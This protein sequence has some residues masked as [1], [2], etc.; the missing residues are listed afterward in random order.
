M[1]QL[2]PIFFFTI[3]F[4]SCVSTKTFREV[5]NRYANLKMEYKSILEKNKLLN[6]S[7]DSIIQFLN[8]KSKLLEIIGDSLMLVKNDLNDIKL[9]YESLESKSDSDI[10]SRI[11]ENNNLLD[12]LAKIHYELKTGLNKVFELEKL[13]LEKEKKLNLLRKNL[14]DALL[15]F[16]G[17]GLK[18]DQRNGKVYVS[19]ENKLLFK[20]GSWKVQPDGRKAIKQ[21][22]NVL[23]GNPEI[24]VLIEGHT[25][26]VPYSGEGVI[27]NNWDLSTKRATAII[28]LLLINKLVLPQNITAAGRGEFF[29]IASNSDEKGRSANRRIEVILTPKLNEI[30]KL[31]ENIN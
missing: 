6:E 23:A 21:L 26:N 8:S 30:S 4:Y 17:N 13:V 19:M 1:K 31:L 27:K 2:K 25:D 12:S 3:L 10:K 20:S 14:S 9:N 18:V 16:E 29:P 24:N 22:S 15:N 11:I 28:N 5:E 7:N